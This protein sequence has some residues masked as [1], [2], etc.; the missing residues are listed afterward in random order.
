[1]AGAQLAVKL[2]IIGMILIG[3]A[4]AI[5]FAYEEYKKQCPEGLMVCLGLE[6]P[7]ITPGPGP[8]PAGPAGPSPSSNTTPLADRSPEYSECTQHFSEED[9][10]KTCYDP[11]NGVGGMRWFWANTTAGKSCLDKTKYY[12]IEASS[13]VDNH[14]FKYTYIKPGGGSN[15]VVFNNA[16]ALT[17]KNGTHFNMKFNITPLDVNKK[18][19]SDPLIG[20]ELNP[21]GDVTTDCTSIG[22]STISFLDNFK[23][24]GGNPPPP[25]PPPPVDCAGT[26]G[27]WGECVSDDPNP[28]CNVTFGNKSRTFTASTP[29]AHGGRACPTKN[30]EQTCLVTT[31]CTEKTREEIQ[32]LPMC[33]Y[34]GFQ[35][36]D[37]DTYK[38]DTSCTTD[39]NNRDGGEMKFERS[40]KDVNYANGSL[41]C[42]PDPS[43]V[44]TKYEPCAQ[45]PMCPIDC[46]GGEVP[47]STADSR[48]WIMSTGASRGG[49][50]YSHKYYDV[51]KYVH[52]TPA[53][54]GGQACPIA[55]NTYMMGEN[56]F[57]SQRAGSKKPPKN[58]WAEYACSK[59]PTTNF[60]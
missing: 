45:R 43:T 23:H 60:P 8:G 28:I 59:L 41:N 18:A 15:G 29:S 30:Q 16:K 48:C 22:T 33:E 31:N 50:T 35:R 55:N 36:S 38:C 11:A 10:T 44:T 17:T 32:K 20:Q 3:L 56:Q 19:L 58:E 53:Q 37:E 40:V 5:Y 9:K 34:T 25:P 4:V 51:K 6:D 42:N 21:G 27:S 13:A 14:K 57:L 1:M 7:E 47:V 39:P 12:K 52:L 49:V 2:G 54:Y 26:W 46:V 24:D